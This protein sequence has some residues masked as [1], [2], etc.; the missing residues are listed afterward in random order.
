MTYPQDN[1]DWTVPG[2]PAIAPPPEVRRGVLFLYF[3]SVAW[4]VA[5]LLACLRAVLNLFMMYSDVG[6]GLF[7]ELV[8]M[9]LWLVAAAAAVALFVLTRQLSQS[10]VKV[11]VAVLVLGWIAFALG[12]MAFLGNILSVIRPQRGPVDVLFEVTSTLQLVVGL[13]VA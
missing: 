6:S 5:N 2:A 9:V 11:R 8:R 13:I 12:A 3:A 10:R 7:E 1:R 4:F